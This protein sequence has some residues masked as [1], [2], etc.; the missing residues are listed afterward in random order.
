M[1]FHVPCTALGLALVA[2]APAAHAQALISSQ[3]VVAVPTTTVR[4]VTIVRTLRRLRHRRV[5]V[6]RRTYVTDR[7]V[8]AATVAAAP[9]IAARYPGPL[10]DY[11]TPAPAP[12]APA[13]Y[14]REPLYDTVATTPVPAESVPAVVPAAVSED[15]A[16]MGP[17]SFYRYVYEP[18]RILVIDPNTG[19]AVQ[20][21][22]R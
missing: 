22:P 2:A 7:I 4:T 18:D 19:V 10:Y 14:Y 1:R 15:P 21:L 17:G 20:A 13:P 16:A 5:V 11:V 3:P 8:P 6:T 12:V 9:A